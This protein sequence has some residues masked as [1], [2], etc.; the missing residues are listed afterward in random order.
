LRSDIDLL[1]ASAWSGA[2]KGFNKVQRRQRLAVRC[3]SDFLPGLDRIKRCAERADRLKSTGF[4]HRPT[5]P[6][7][8]KS[9]DRLGALFE[10]SMVTRRQ[11]RAKLDDRTQ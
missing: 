3:N 2:H 7:G 10:T 8:C 11:T 1:A 5:I 6:P 4:A 9:A